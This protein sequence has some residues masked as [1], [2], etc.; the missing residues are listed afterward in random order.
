MLQVLNLVLWVVAAGLCVAPLY[1]TYDA[2]R[3]G[4][5]TSLTEADFYNAFSRTSWSLGLSYLIIACSLGQ[6]GTVNFVI[7]FV[8]GDTDE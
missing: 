5:V 6:G 1:G 3:G 2:N 4:H 8:K 7:G